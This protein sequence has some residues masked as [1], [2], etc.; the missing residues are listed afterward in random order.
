MRT[1]PQND[2]TPRISARGSEGE[3]QDYGGANGGGHGLR[4]MARR[5]KKSKAL[6]R[7]GRALC[8]ERT[9]SGRLCRILIER[10]DLNPAKW[11]ERH[12]SA[13]CFLHREE[14]RS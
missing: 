11:R 8:S 2:R 3:T 13:P 10:C 9:K 7:R 1:I 4:H 12:R 5:G 14:V 6:A